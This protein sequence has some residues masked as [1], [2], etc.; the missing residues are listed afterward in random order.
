MDFKDYYRILGVPDTADEKEIKASYR[1]TFSVCCKRLAP[2]PG[3]MR[4]T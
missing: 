2:M 3:S 1:K 4:R